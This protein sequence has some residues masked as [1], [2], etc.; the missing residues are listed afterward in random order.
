MGR[1]GKGGTS[2]VWGKRRGKSVEKARNRRGTGVEK[3]WK[4]ATKTRATHMW[5]EWVGRMGG[6]N[7][8]G[9]MGWRVC[10]FDSRLS[11]HSLLRIATRSDKSSEEVIPGVLVDRDDEFPPA[12]LR[13]PRLERLH[14]FR[15][16]C[17]ELLAAARACRVDLCARL[18]KDGLRRRGALVGGDLGSAAVGELHQQVDLVHPL[19]DLRQRLLL[20]SRHVLKRRE[21]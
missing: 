17:L 5:E 15:T 2:R 20:L 8:G 16:L 9:R 6:K 21:G 19:L 11:L 1:G 18:V 12:S 3:V 14:Q 7:G 13:R 4:R 10:V